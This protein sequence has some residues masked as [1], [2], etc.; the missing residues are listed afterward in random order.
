MEKSPKQE[1][2]SREAVQSWVKKDLASAHYLLGVLLHRY[3]D[4]IN[5]L[6]NDV[7]DHAMKLENGAAIDHV[8]AKPHEDA[9]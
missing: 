8:Q 6:A 2:P 5:S 7:Y 9:D 3:P 4:V 1:A